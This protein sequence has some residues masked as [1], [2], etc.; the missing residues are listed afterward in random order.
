[1][2]PTGMSVEVD[3]DGNVRFAQGVGAS[4]KPPSERQSTLALFSGLMTE[5]MPE[6]SRLESLE[7]FNPA[8]LGEGIAAKTG[9]FGNYIRTEEG[10][11]YQG[12]ARQWAEGVLRIQTGAAATQPEIERVMETYFPVPGDTENTVRQKSQQ[13]DAFARSLVV[14]SGGNLAAPGGAADRG[15]I[16]VDA[17]SGGGPKRL[18]FNP[19]TGGFEE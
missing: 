18:K 14:A 9:W 10:Q 15:A 16:G 19:E 4:K 1:M 17:T 13:R 12:L 5:T 8:G 7:G 6:I 2:A 3:A 11:R